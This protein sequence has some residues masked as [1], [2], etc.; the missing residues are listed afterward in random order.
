M[1]GGR[2][3]SAISFCAQHVPSQA[4]VLSEDRGLSLVRH[5]AGQELPEIVQITP[6]GLESMRPV[7]T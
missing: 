2:H 3:R 4:L 6:L 1:G 7:E 5:R